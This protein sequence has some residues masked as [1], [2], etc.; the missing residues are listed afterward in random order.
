[1]AID[2]SFIPPGLVHAWRDKNTP[3]GLELLAFCFAWHAVFFCCI[4]TATE[5][6]FH[7]SVSMHQRLGEQSLELHI[8]RTC[9]RWEANQVFGNASAGLL[10]TEQLLPWLR[11]LPFQLPVCVLLRLRAHWTRWL[12][13]LLYGYFLVFPVHGGVT[14]LHELA[15]ASGKINYISKAW[16]CLIQTTAAPVPSALVPLRVRI[17]QPFWCIS[18]FISWICYRHRWHV[19]GLHH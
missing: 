3:Q 6:F 1:M 18:C 16:P 8:S 7:P 14:P 5:K 4:A 17:L 10:A 12:T 13:D 2:Y 9:T 19:S 15:T 11:D